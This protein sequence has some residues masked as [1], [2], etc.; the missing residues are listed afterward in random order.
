MDVSTAPL[1]WSVLVTVSVL[2]LL[3]LPLPDSHWLFSTQM[4]AMNKNS[5]LFYYTHTHTIVSNLMI[6]MFIDKREDSLVCCHSWQNIQSLMCHH[7][8]NIE[9][10]GQKIDPSYTVTPQHT[11]TGTAILATKKTTIY[12]IV[13]S[14]PYPLQQKGSHY[15]TLLN[16]LQGNTHSPFTRLLSQWN[17]THN[18][19]VQQLLPC[20]HGRHST[21]RSPARHKTTWKTL[22]LTLANIDDSRHPSPK[23]P[24]S[25]QFYTNYMQEPKPI[26]PDHPQTG[27]IGSPPLFCSAFITM[28]P[29]NI[30]CT[31]P[32]PG[33]Q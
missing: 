16:F 32:P 9:R 27:V 4:L 3:P 15:F 11:T 19:L 1:S 17:T 22:S 23:E 8:H 31:H 25:H 6:L 14:P 18:Q 24:T 29:H 28:Q 21:Q 7:H 2:L 20:P 13:Y 12:T 10:G 26:T 30:S 33:L 5:I